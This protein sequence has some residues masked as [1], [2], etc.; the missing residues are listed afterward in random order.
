[1]YQQKQHHY[2]Q[3]YNKNSISSNRITYL[4]PFPTHDNH[5][6]HH[7]QF[8]KVNNN[9]S[10]HIISGKQQLF[11]DRI[12]VIWGRE[13]L[14]VYC[15]FLRSCDFDVLCYVIL[16]VYVYVCVFVCLCLCVCFCMCMYVCM[17]VCACLCVCEREKE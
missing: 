1:M 8:Q 10:L 11:F 13:V 17:C 7:Q 6:S 12:V 2:Q 4:I 15:C 16:C 9:K 14:F 5:Y 3:Q